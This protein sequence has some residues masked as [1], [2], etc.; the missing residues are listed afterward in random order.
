MQQNTPDGGTISTTGLP[1]AFAWTLESLRSRVFFKMMDAVLTAPLHPR[2]AGR[3]LLRTILT[4]R[5]PHYKRIASTINLAD[6][7]IP[8]LSYRISKSLVSETHLPFAVLSIRLMSYGSGSTVFL[9]D[10]PGGWN[11]LKV[12]RR[13]LGKTGPNLLNLTIEFQTKYL[14]V[15]RWFN[16]EG[17]RLVPPAL[18][19][20]LHGP[21]LG[22]PAAA[23][24]Q[25]FL[26][27][28][29]KDLFLDY[30]DSELLGLFKGDRELKRQFVH[31]AR[32]VL[33]VAAEEGV[34]MDFIGRHNVVLI[35]DH[36]GCR[37]AVIDNGIFNMEQIRVTRPAIYEQIQAYLERIRHLLLALEKEENDEEGGWIDG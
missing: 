4:L 28:E 12:F 36:T 2:Q 19:L 1:E 23:T 17:F 5:S 27:G 37:L 18:F 7:I 13:S 25:P 29:L 10:T 11:V 34:C 32:K 20:L 14:T 3:S 16:Q 35:Q 26:S 30:Q 6:R 24:L 33:Q 9:L 8:G 15:S 31:F 21:L 22:K